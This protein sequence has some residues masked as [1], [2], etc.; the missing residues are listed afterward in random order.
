VIIREPKTGRERGQSKAG[1]CF[2]I[3]LSVPLW[4]FSLRDSDDAAGRSRAARRE[5]GRYQG[6]QN[7]KY[8]VDKSTW[9]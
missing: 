1:K 2:D 3:L 4:I 9:K 7:E 6:Y 8:S 5:V